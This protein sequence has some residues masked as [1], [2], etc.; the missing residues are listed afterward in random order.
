MNNKR[1][2]IFFL[3]LV[4]FA[5][6][7]FSQRGKNILQVG[8]NGLLGSSKSIYQVGYGINGSYLWAISPSFNLG[9]ELSVYSIST[10]L[11]QN[12]LQTISTHFD[13]CYFPKKLIESITKKESTVLDGFYFNS[14]IGHNFKTNDVFDDVV[15]N[16]SHVGFG[17]I[18]P[19]SFYYNLSINM[20]ALNSGFLSEQKVNNGIYTLTVGIALFKKGGTTQGK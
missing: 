8:V 1:F 20:F 11:G 9:P 19:G 6:N 12:S 10:N 3:C 14:G 18:F 15:L 2:I 13:V 7:V 5:A 16:T 4:F 17:Y